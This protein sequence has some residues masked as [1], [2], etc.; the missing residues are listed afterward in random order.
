M[1][2]MVVEEDGDVLT[3][4]ARP[5]GGLTFT[6]RAEGRTRSCVT[7]A[8]DSFD[9][10]EFLEGEHYLELPNRGH[11]NSVVAFEY[12]GGSPSIEIIHNAFAYYVIL[13]GEDAETFKEM[14]YPSMRNKD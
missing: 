10:L 8:D 14:V 12:L 2:E 1:I 11:L 5:E 13:E 6:M 3:I 7:D 4:S 9:I